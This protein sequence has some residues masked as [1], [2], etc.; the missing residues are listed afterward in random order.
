MKISKKE[1]NFAFFAVAAIAGEH[2]TANKPIKYDNWE[3]IF[4]T[5]A[6]GLLGGT[7]GVVREDINTFIRNS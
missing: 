4:K 5:L 3:V 6:I 1:K 7:F 2:L